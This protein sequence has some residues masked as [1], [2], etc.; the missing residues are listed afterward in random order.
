MLYNGE[1][2]TV[3]DDGWDINDAH[4]A[5][6]QLGFSSASGGYGNAI[7]GQGYGRIWMDDVGCHGYESSL[8]DCQH[9]G[10]GSHNCAHS[11]DASVI[12]RSMFS[13]RFL[14]F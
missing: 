12:C 14:C 5:C 9:S 6:K 10:F 1:W 8:S 13:Y 11:E 3:C 4:V 7:Y 2:G